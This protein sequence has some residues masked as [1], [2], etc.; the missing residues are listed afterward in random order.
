MLW[1]HG[2]LHHLRE[3]CC[4]PTDQT[5]QGLAVIKQAALTNSGIGVRQQ[6]SHIRWDSR[7]IILRVPTVTQQDIWQSGF[8]QECLGLFVFLPK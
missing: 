7:R 5:T 4:W 1:D 3:R 2:L 6:F 8:R